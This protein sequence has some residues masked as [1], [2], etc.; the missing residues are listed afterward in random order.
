MNVQTN[1][2]FVDW[3]RGMKIG[4]WNRGSLKVGGFDEFLFG[5]ENKR[6][7]RRDNL[8]QTI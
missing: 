1:S 7:R 8:K 2:N 3:A 5:I 6:E 4:L